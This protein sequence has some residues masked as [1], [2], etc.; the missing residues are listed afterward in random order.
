M[1][2]VT[3]YVVLMQKFIDTY[4]YAFNP[5]PGWMPGDFGKPGLTGTLSQTVSPKLKVL[6]QKKSKSLVLLCAL[7]CDC[8]NLFACLLEL[9]FQTY[10]TRAWVG[11]GGWK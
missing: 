4:D 1:I 5:K 11:V 8:A 6:W 2:P 10:C 9:K 7:F 3:D